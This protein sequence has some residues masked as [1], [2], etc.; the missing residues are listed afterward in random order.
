M[1]NTFDTLDLKAELYATQQLASFALALAHQLSGAAPEALDLIQEA[2]IRQ[3]QAV[4][5]NITQGQSTSGQLAQF[6]IAYEKGIENGVT[7]TKGYLEDLRRIGGPER[8]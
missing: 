5:D 2:L 8:N 3:H 7:L 4:A 6:S 1:E